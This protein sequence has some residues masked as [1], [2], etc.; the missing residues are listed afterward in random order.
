MKKLEQSAGRR[1][2]PTGNY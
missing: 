1:H 2:F